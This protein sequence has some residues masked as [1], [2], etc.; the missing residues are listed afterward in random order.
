MDRVWNWAI[1]KVQQTE[2]ASDVILKDELFQSF[3]VENPDLPRDTFLS[4]FGRF[5]GNAPFDSVAPLQ[6]RRKI[7]GSVI[8]HLK[9]MKQLKRI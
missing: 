3:Q 4:F 6:K 5:M 9:V 7:W 2:R 1:R 8:C